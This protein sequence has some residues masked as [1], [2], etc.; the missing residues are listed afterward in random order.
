MDASVINSASQVASQVA[1]LSTPGPAPRKVGERDPQTALAPV[2]TPAEAE[3]QAALKQ[4]SDAK[5]AARSPSTEAPPSIGRIRFELEDGTRVA[6]FFDTK[7]I[8][9]YQVPPEGTIYLVRLQEAADQDQIETS[10]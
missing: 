4:L 1:G 10:A 2:D 7:D 5:E 3:K 8:L 6:R 9:I